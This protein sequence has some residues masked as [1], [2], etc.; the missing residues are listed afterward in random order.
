VSATSDLL[1]FAR[2]EHK[3][4]QAVG[5]AARR[6]LAD[7]LAVGA[8]GALVSGE[9]E[10]AA[11]R[12]GGGDEARSLGRGSLWPAPSAA[13]VN[14]FRT[15]CLEWDAVHEGAVVHALAV[16]TAALGAA[17]DRK[18]GCDPEEALTALAVGVD[19][20]SGLGIAST[21][22]MRFFRPATAGESSLSKIKPPRSA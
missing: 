11:A 12:W 19:V 10:S 5:E 8:A 17:I 18:G 1:D 13:F 15:H 21:G 6:L 7:T 3:L 14:G 20:A 16:V 22:A 4:P 9:V 2:A